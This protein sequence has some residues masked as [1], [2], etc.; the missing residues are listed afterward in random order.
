MI[1][2]DALLQLCKDSYNRGNKDALDAFKI[3]FQRV[4]EVM[5]RKHFSIDEIISFINAAKDLSDEIDKKIQ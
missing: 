5:G 2:A 4:S 3:S 1:E